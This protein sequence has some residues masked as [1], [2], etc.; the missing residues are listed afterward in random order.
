MNTSTNIEMSGIRQ[1]RR[2]VLSDKSPITNSILKNVKYIDIY[3]KVHDDYCAKSTSGSI[4]SILVYILVIILTIGE[5]WRYIEG[6][7]VEHI[8]VDD[9]MNQK[10]D[11][12]LDI[13]FPSLRCNEISVDTVD[14]VGENQVNAHGN[15]LKIPIDIHGNEVQEET[16]TQYNESTSSM[17][18]LSC[19]GAE[20]IHYKC[21]NTCESL[22]NAFRYKGW[23]YLDIASKAPQC[24]DTIGC[25]LHGSLQV[26]K[27]SGNIHVA[28]GQATV[29]DGKHVHEFNM[30]DISRGFNT[31]HTIHELRFGKDNI[32]FIESPLE[33]TKKIVTT[34]TSMF[35][36]YLKLV[37]TQFIKSGYNKILFS[38]QYTYT[39]RQKDVLVK[40]GELSGLPGVFIVY[41]FQPFVI[42]KIH[43]SIPITHFLTSFCAIIGGIYSLMSLIDSI[44]FW[45][46]KR[47]SAILSG[48]FKSNY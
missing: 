9:N 47:T 23:S 12:R 14:N 36:Y 40:D 29:R 44:L 8:G 15:L 1:R 2:G 20:S 24:I 37:P 18:C 6:E 4:I 48:N 43:N 42:R 21:C 22:K 35:H 34:G 26:N 7:T 13:S 46:I 5:F 39:E 27:V 25:R 17:K 16:M 33:N 31:S 10:L 45:F 30:N 19:F 11:I 41:D 32:E 38:N 3:G 28:L